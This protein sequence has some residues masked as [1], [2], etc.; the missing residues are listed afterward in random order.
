MNGKNL[1]GRIKDKKKVGHKTIQIFLRY[2]KNKKC[3]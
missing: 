2:N 1:T 3:T